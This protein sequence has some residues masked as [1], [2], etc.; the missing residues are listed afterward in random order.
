M[1]I[2]LR[3]HGSLLEQQ[4]SLM[5]TCCLAHFYRG[6]LMQRQICILMWMRKK[7]GENIKQLGQEGRARPGAW[8][9]AVLLRAPLSEWGD[10]SATVTSLAL[11]RSGL[12]DVPGWELREELGGRRDP[13][14]KLGH[15]CG[16][17]GDGARLI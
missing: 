4:R 17:T 3:I 12:C 14:S 8:L 5:F 6:P 9:L 11:W 15:S 1:D 13:V 7:L 16:R 10:P 2:I